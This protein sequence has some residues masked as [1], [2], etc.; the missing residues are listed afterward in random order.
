ML[1]AYDQAVV[2][3]ER[4]IKAHPTAEGHTFLG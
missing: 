4:S 3:F 1:G 2:L